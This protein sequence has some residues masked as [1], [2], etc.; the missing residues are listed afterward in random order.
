MVLA[1]VTR[2]RLRSARH[3]LG[4]FR[5]AAR[6]L[7][8]ARGAA[9]NLG[10]EV[11]RTKRLAFWTLTVWESEEAMRAYVKAPPHREAMAKL[12]GWCDEAAYTRWRH[13]GETPPDWDDAARH[14]LA[15][16]RL[17]KVDRPSQ[18]QSAGEIATD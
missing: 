2:L 11:R 7:K 15:S 8:A 14:L 6:S 13:E 12:A 4:F 16:G 18:R 3:L 5:H 10:A 17:S 9:G 1:S